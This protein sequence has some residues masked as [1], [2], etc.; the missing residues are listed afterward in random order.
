MQI[1]IIVYNYKLRLFVLVNY[2]VS[3]KVMTSEK[4]MLYRVFTYFNYIYLLVSCPIRLEMTT[5]TALTSA[6]MSLS[7][8]NQDILGKQ[9]VTCRGTQGH[10]IRV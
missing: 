8:E 4:H 1:I 9:A 2:N 5:T 3:I 7:S 6:I 10:G